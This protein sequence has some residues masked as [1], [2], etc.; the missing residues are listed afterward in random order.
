MWLG[1]VTYVY[2]LYYIYLLISAM[3]DLLSDEIRSNFTSDY[4]AGFWARLVIGLCTVWVAGCGEK[5]IGKMDPLAL[6]QNYVIQ[7]LTYRPVY[8]FSCRKFECWFE[9]H[10]CMSLIFHYV[11]KSIPGQTPHIPVFQN[12]SKTPILTR[13]NDNS[14][15]TTWPRG[16]IRVSPH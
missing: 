1:T 8:T 3:M 10:I 15:E 2:Y 16:V 14:S 9:S 11:E 13:W 12:G 4:D 6:Y 5:K 7:A